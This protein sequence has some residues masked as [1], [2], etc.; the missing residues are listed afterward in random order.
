MNRDGKWLCNNRACYS[1]PNGTYAGYSISGR[2]GNISRDQARTTVKA[3]VYLNGF[4]VVIWNQLWNHGMGILLTFGNTGMAAGLSDYLHFKGTAE[5]NVKIHHFLAIQEDA[6][7]INELLPSHHQKT[8]ALKHRL[9]GSFINKLDYSF[10]NFGIGLGCWKV[11]FAHAICWKVAT[12]HS[13]IFA[14]FYVLPL[15]LRV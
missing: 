9:R 13:P 8:P 12:P 1:Q 11:V 7:I 5:G 15:D 14:S 10:Q 4:L 3:W 2:G 6:E